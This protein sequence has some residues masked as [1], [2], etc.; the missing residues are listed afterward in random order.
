MS[1]S[2][3][4]LDLLLVER[5]L[6]A[7][8]NRA[9]ALIRAGE[10]RV[11]GQVFDKPGMSVPRSARIELRE[12]LPYVGRAGGKLAAALDAF[13]IDPAGRICLDVGASTGGFTDC[14]L[15]RGAHRVYAVDVG[16][17]QLAWPLRQDPRVVNLERQDIRRLPELPEPIELAV[18]D[19]SFISLRLVLP[20]VFPRLTDRAPIIAL[21]KPQFEAGRDQ[22][23]K[24]GIVREPE[25]HAR[26]LASILRWAETQGWHASAAIASPIT[27]SAG[28]REFLALLTPAPPTSRESDSSPSDRI[29][30]ALTT[31]GLPPLPSSP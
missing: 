20:A 28:N 11:D 6:C 4:R 9:Q 16:R 7:S 18:V 5:G 19:V 10:V 14:L 2:K 12:R 26:V 22:V 1:A 23:G 29:A 8:R 21:V 30:T 24:G 13:D 25:V 17:A 31:A 3:Q 15:Q 27:G